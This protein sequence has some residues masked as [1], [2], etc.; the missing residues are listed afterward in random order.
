MMARVLAADFLKIR[1]KA[2]WF[3][4]FLGPVGVI[5]LQAVN[6][7]LRY[8]YLT[9]LHASDLWGGMLSDI[10]HLVP[11]TILLGITIVASMV[12]N[13]EHQVSSW[14]QLLVLPISR[15]S[16][17][18]AKFTLCVLLLLVSCILLGIGTIVLG[19]SLG[20]ETDFPLLKII[21]LSFYPFIAAFPILALQLWL[22]VV[23]KNQAF[24]L[25]VGI[26]GAIFSPFALKFPDWFLWK[27]PMLMN[28]ANK[29]EYSVFAG[30]A[31]GAV[32]FAMGSIHFTSKDVN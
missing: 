25:T 26:V 29:P 18:S 3:L 8:D 20:Y 24:P 21:K 30:L 22:S 15:I 27:L 4:I 32:I 5:A 12:A 2:I 17:F 11:L 23:T 10:Q 16:V 9:K 13:I 28:A 19:I 14:K 6:Y 1:R 31:A 7:G